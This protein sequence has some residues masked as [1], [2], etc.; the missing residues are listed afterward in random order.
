[1]Q[2]M[3]MGM[4]LLVLTPVLGF[5]Q[6]FTN[7]CRETI[8]AQG[9]LPGANRSRPTFQVR[10]L[11]SEKVIR[12]RVLYQDRAAHVRFRSSNLLEYEV[13][14]ENSRRLKFSSRDTNGVPI[15]ATFVVCDFGRGTNDAFGVFVDSGYEK[16]SHIRRGSIILR[17]RHCR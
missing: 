12:G 3:R 4:L 9:A 17:Q 10:T 14:D 1:M 5:A 16:I 7:G 2:G 13:M 8:R 15:I 6:T 11:V